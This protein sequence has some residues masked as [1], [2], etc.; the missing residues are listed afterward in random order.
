MVSLTRSIG[1]DYNISQTLS[2]IDVKQWKIEEAEVGSEMSSQLIMKG[3]A[4]RHSQLPQ[5]SHQLLPQN[6]NL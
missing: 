4:Y 3:C 1:R 6:A 5:R 2:H